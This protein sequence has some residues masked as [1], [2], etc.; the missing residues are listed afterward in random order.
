M[1]ILCWGN[2]KIRPNQLL[3]GLKYLWKN[4]NTNPVWR[5]VAVSRMWHLQ[6]IPSSGWEQLLMP[7]WSLAASSA[8]VP[9]GSPAGG[10][11]PAPGTVKLGWCGHQCSM[12]SQASWAVPATPR[13]SFFP[14]NYFCSW[15]TSRGA[16]CSG[17]KEVT[18]TWWQQVSA[19][20]LAPAEPA[21]G[22]SSHQGRE[23]GFL[24]ASLIQYLHLA[25]ETSLVW[26]LRSRHLP[27]RHLQLGEVSPGYLSTADLAIPLPFPWKT[28]GTPGNQSRTPQA[29]SVIFT[30]CGIWDIS[31]MS[32]LSSTF[33]F[34]SV[35]A[36][37]GLKPCKSTDIEATVCM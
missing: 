12:A 1:T 7:S 6:A 30:H 2:S 31:T 26:Q 17:A 13:E 8:S 35:E 29:L 20:P 22:S 34:F 33:F 14:E 15:R 32:C 10:T 18:L 11:L 36:R 28:T 19:Q 3:K 24:R 5:K 21:P 4:V 27:H 23:T 25:D 37:W 16:A 9:P